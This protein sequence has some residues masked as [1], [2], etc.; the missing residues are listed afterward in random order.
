LTPSEVCNLF[1]KIEE[2]ADMFL[3]HVEPDC[4]YQCTITVNLDEQTVTLTEIDPFEEWPEEE[5]E[6][7]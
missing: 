1:R 7:A 4:G 5:E 3:K 2:K 6:D